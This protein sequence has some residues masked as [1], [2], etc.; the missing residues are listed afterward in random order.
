MKIG[1]ARLNCLGHLLTDS[2][3]AISPDKLSKIEDWPLPKTGKQF[4][5]FLGLLTF[6]RQHV[7]HFADITAG[8]EA[9]KRTKG[10]I[11]WTP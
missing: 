7:R 3:V 2:G 6:V 1:Q 5:S 9:V 10:E 4:A 11:T 8:L